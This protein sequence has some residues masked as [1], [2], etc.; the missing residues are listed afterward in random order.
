[1]FKLIVLTLFLV[2]CAHTAVEQKGSSNEK[3][4]FSFR[5][6]TLGS[7]PNQ[8]MILNDGYSKSIEQGFN[9]LKS[10]EK[11]QEKMSI[12]PLKLRSISYHYV[13][14]RLFQILISFN[15]RIYC[16]EARYMLEAI[17]RKYGI[18]L[19]V[20]SEQPYTQMMAHYADTELEVLLHCTQA[21]GKKAGV[22][23]SLISFMDTKLN[24]E[25][26]SI[27]SYINK[28]IKSSIINQRIRDF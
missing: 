9:Q 26:E 11:P 23:E 7:K 3:T 14:D 21:L 12:G 10:Y 25:A 28:E 13:N 2:G 24:Q 27:S 22:N 18:R 1:M 20:I 19:T 17:E 8:L 5:G 4:P 16:N 6:I 15:D